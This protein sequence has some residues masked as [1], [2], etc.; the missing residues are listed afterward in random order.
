MMQLIFKWSGKQPGICDKS[1]AEVLQY[2]Q[3]IIQCQ[4]LQ[5]RRFGHKVRGNEIGLD[6]LQLG[7]CILSA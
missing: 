7:M 4:L 3:H 5:S 2:I 1:F 6:Q